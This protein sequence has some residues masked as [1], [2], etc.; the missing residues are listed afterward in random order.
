M[1]KYSV[2]M[3]RA[4]RGVISSV[5]IEVKAKNATAARRAAEIELPGWNAHAT[6]SVD[7]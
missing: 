7:E 2:E 1:K 5:A 3:R 6:I 4:V